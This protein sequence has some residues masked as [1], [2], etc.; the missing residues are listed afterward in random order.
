[1]Y[2]IESAVLIIEF[3]LVCTISQDNQVALKQ[4]IYTQKNNF[5]WFTDNQLQLELRGKVLSS[6]VTLNETRI[7]LCAIGDCKSFLTSYMYLNGFECVIFFQNKQLYPWHSHYKELINCTVYTSN[8][9]MCLPQILKPLLIFCFVAWQTS[10]II[11]ISKV[12]K[13]FST[14]WKFDSARYPAQ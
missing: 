11:Q 8:R 1:M 13:L 5:E 12:R 14:L 10:N 2:T 7:L 3:K 6:T 4:R 9:N